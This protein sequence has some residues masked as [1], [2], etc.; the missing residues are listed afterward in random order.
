MQIARHV[1]VTVLN[2]HIVAR[3]RVITCHDHNTIT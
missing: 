2:H 1:S 3:I